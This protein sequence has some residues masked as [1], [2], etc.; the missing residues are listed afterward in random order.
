M[1]ITDYYCL[2]SDSNLVHL[3]EA[4]DFEEADSIAQ[5]LGI[6][7]IWIF[8]QEIADLWLARLTYFKTLHHHDHSSQVPGQVLPSNQIQ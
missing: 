6:E 5:S 4:N 8:N 3:G 2:T 7:S 1:E